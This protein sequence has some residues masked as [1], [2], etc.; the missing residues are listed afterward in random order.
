MLSIFYLFF[1]LIVLDKSNSWNIPSVRL[2]KRNHQ[3]NFLHKKTLANSLLFSTSSLSSPSLPSPT[4]S[5]SSLPSPLPPSSTS[6]ESFHFESNVGNLMDILINSIYLNKDVFLRELISNSIDAC[7]KKNMLFYQNQ[8]KLLSSSSPPPQNLIRVS[9]EKD[10]KLLIIEDTGIGMNKTSLINNLGKIAE[11]GTKKFQ[12]NKKDDEKEIVKEGERIKLREEKANEFSSFIGQFGVGFYSSFLVSDYV[13]VISRSYEDFLEGKSAWKWTATRSN[14]TSYHIEEIP[15]VTSSNISTSN[16]STFSSEINNKF[17]GT[18]IILYLSEENDKYLNFNKLRSIIENYI[19]YVEIP[20]QILKDDNIEINNENNEKKK[21]KNEKK[22]I[23]INSLGPLWLRSPKNCTQENYLQFYHQ[24]FNKENYMRFLSQYVDDIDS[25]RASPANTSLVS[26]ASLSN[27]A[28]NTSSDVSSILPNSP[29]L[30][31]YSSFFNTSGTSLQPDDPLGYL[32]FSVDGSVSFSS[33]IYIPSKL[34]KKQEEDM[35]Y[36]DNNIRLYHKNV[37]LNNIDSTSSTS[38]IT[39]LFFPRWLNFLKGIINCNTINLTLNRNEI[40]LEKNLFLIN[41][42][43]KKIISKLILYFYQLK[44]KNFSKFMEFWKIY[45]KYIKIGIIE[46]EEYREDLLPLAHFYSSKLLLEE[47]EKQKEKDAQYGK[48]EEEKENLALRSLTTLAEYVRRMKLKNNKQKKIFYY[49]TPSSSSSL[50]L[51]SPISSSSTSSS[52]PLSHSSS[53][54][55]PILKNFLKKNYEVLILPDALSEMA[56]KSVSTY[57]SYPLVDI[58]REIYIDDEEENEIKEDSEELTSNSS[59]SSLSKKSTLS[60]EQIDLILHYNSY[61]SQ[62]LSDKILVKPSPRLS[63][64]DPLALFL[65][66][67]SAPSPHI[68]SFLRLQGMLQ[69]AQDGMSNHKTEDA[70]NSPSS[71]S[72]NNK[73]ISRYNS[74]ESLLSIL[75]DSTLELN[76]NHPLISFMIEL[77]SKGEKEKKKLEQIFLLIF[78]S[79]A[80]A[81]GYPIPNPTEFNDL[82]ITTLLP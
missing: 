60:K 35:F 6:S 25:L 1:F 29:F 13:E 74:P 40:K 57:Q 73:Y 76:L 53:S 19:E 44:Q 10:K 71:L 5:S 28:L 41:S 61:F 50:S 21:E 63:Q 78:L 46:D 67:P 23:T 58:G 80:Q 15:L 49:V 8:K 27:S 30:S 34:S 39:P 4:P 38:S 59:L 36:N 31:S 3:I 16:N 79:S 48:S 65:P 47:Q 33:L 14:M 42:I 81:C 54:S 11:S 66:G 7:T 70:E 75:C 72:S 82:I 32:H 43:K 56:L 2:N 12:Q 55:S 20:I 52:S 68:L 17:Y 62:H 9:M 77:N 24:T 64:D 22:F 37:L 45:G 26:A 18:K 51:L 69:E